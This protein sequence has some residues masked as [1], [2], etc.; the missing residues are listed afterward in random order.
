MTIIEE[1]H[2]E[3]T[4]NKKKLTKYNIKYL[5]G[6]LQPILRHTDKK[7]TTNKLYIKPNRETQFCID[8]CRL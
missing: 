4:A 1:K 7:R 2:I 8:T 6:K 5:N 3:K